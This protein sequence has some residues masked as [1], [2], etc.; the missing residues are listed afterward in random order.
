VLARLAR[1]RRRLFEQA[2]ALDEPDFRR[3]VAQYAH[4]AELRTSREALQREIVAALGTQYTEESLRLKLAS[5]APDK[6]EAQWETLSGRL[7]QCETSLKQRFEQRGQLNHEIELLAADRRLPE[8]HLELGLV[9]QRLKEAV[10][11]WQVRAATSSILESVR[12]RY[13]RDR[14]PQTLRDASELLR[15]LTAGRYPRV[16]TPMDEDRLLVDDAEGQP[17]AVEILSR[18]T[19]EQLFLALRLALVR[20]YARGG[21]RL[22]LVLDDVLVN[23]DAARAKAAASLLAEFAAEGHQV[24]VFTCHEHIARLMRTLRAP[25]T[26]LPNRHDLRLDAPEPRAPKRPRSRRARRESPAPAAIALP[27]AKPTVELPL[28]VAVPLPDPPR[29]KPLVEELPPLPI[30]GSEAEFAELDPVLP[31]NREPLHIDDE[32][33][34]QPPIKP[35]PAP[36]ALKPVR[37]PLPFF[38]GESAE[39]FSGEFAIRPRYEE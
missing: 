16:W 23:F 19:R 32:L 10:R 30:N 21:V 22:P 26:E 25:V 3:R 34:P 27:E 4:V 8:R 13:E 28:P 9:E 39:E 20:D 29:A 5:L 31:I 14:Q 35:A 36:P 1:Q 18:G 37:S 33:R 6:L 15:E 12:S 38:R 11:E 24:L 2:G 17:L 7:A